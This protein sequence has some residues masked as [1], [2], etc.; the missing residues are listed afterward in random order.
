MPAPLIAISRRL[1]RAVGALSFGSPVAHTYN[2]LV[3]AAEPHERY[4]S[5]FGV[6]TG[7]ILLL[8]MNPGPFGMAQT[9]VP[10]GEVAMVRDWMGIEGRVGRPADEHPARRVEGFALARSEVSG[11]RLWGWA[12]QRFGTA[13]RF[14]ERFFVVNYCPLLFLA[15]SGRNLTP[16][17]VS[18][19]EREQL[20]QICDASL[21]DVVAL[22]DPGRVIGVG[23]WA[24]DR[25]R[26]ALASSPWEGPVGR[27]LHPSPA[28][29]AANRGWAAQAEAQLA[30][31]GVELGP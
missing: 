28:S 2:P 4:L 25:A 10:F 1:S 17:K 29:P 24:E 21:R 19:G 13:Q 14:F 23:R 26:A 12:Q 20:L 9:G 5:R 8:G 18:R 22:L 7:R 3:Y 15:A 31:Q 27:V 6:G 16:D 30:A 11:R